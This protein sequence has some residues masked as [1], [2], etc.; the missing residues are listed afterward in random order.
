VKISTAG[1]VVAF[2]VMAGLCLLAVL[3]CRSHPD[4]THFV[5]AKEYV[6]AVAR[7]S[8]GPAHQDDGCV[9]RLIATCRRTYGELCATFLLLSPS[10]MRSIEAT[11]EAENSAPR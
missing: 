3:W 2:L 1:P 6:E 11:E 7:Q 9:E 4:T 10:S 5:A 8:C